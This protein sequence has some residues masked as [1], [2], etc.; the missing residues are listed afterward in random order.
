MIVWYRIFATFSLY[1]WLITLLTL[2][3]GML[4]SSESILAAHVRIA[5][6][7]TSGRELITD[8]GKK[9]AKMRFQHLSYRWLSEI[10]FLPPFPY[11]IDGLLFW[12]EPT[13]CLSRL[14]RH[15]HSINWQHMWISRGRRFAHSV[16]T[17]GRELASI[18]QEHKGDKMRFHHLSYRWLSDITH[19]CA[20]SHHGMSTRTQKGAAR[21]SS[22][23]IK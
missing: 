7:S 4:V 13:V 19:P 8:R 10:A 23:G 9:V 3:D 2:A 12:R 14:S 21:T 15:W 17:S 22:F 16:S 5:R 18:R 6:S 11:T 20:E 1:D